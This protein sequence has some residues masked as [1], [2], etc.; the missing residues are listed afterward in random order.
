MKLL[1]TTIFKSDGISVRY[2]LKWE[3][4]CE[5]HYSTTGKIHDAVITWNSNPACR[6][7]KRTS[8]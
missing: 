1:D 2:S 8:K 5:T 3:D 4:K 7:H 6:E